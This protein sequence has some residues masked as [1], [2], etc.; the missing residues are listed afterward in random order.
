MCS[1]IGANTLSKL[2]VLYEANV[3][4]GTF[5]SSVLGLY[6]YD[7]QYV[8]KQEGIIEFNKVKIDD[9]FDFFISHMQAPTSSKRNWSQDTSHPF[10]SLNWMVLHN[11]V[12]TNWKSLNKEYTPWN[13]NPVDTSVIASMLQEFSTGDTEDGKSPPPIDVVTKVLELLEGTFALCIVNTSTN[14]VYLARQGSLLH[15][16]SSGTFSTLPG[17]DYK[18]LEEGE[19]LMIENYDPWIAVGENY[20]MW[21]SVGKFKTKSPFLFV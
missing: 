14:T 10:E 13:V 19:I 8:H 12:L 3:E 16:H 21:K 7:K 5:A 17:K 1:I 4:R 9:S 11:G 15:Y 18:L 2:E 20:D 6:N